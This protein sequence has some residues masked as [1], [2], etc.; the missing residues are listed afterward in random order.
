MQTNDELLAEQLS[1]DAEFRT[2][3]GAHALG[4]AL[5]LAI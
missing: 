5:A 1:D 2:K 3:W 4:R